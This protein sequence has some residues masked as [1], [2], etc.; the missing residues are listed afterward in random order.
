[1]KKGKTASATPEELDAVETEVFG[2]AIVDEDGNEVPITDKMIKKACNELDKQWTY[3]EK[4]EQEE[5]QQKASD[6]HSSDAEK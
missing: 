3:P 2:A 6:Q 4:S 5:K 1:M